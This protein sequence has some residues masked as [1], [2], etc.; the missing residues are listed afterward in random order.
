MRAGPR[1][2]DVELLKKR[3][4]FPSTTVISRGLAVRSAERQARWR[5]DVDWRGVSFTRPEKRII[6][7]SHVDHRDLVRFGRVGQ[8]TSARARVLLETFGASGGRVAN[9]AL[10]AL[11]ITTIER[12]LGVDVDA[13]H[14][15]VCSLALDMR[16]FTQRAHEL[17]VR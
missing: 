1:C 13:A 15:G 2:S 17:V 3:V 14:L 9:E 5:L 11:A 16:H 10:K 8:V 6:S 7:R 4:G 12:E